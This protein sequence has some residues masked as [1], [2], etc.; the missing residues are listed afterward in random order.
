MN[1]LR[2][3]IPVARIIDLRKRKDWLNGKE[4][5]G[6]SAIIILLSLIFSIIVSGYNLFSIP[7]YRLGD[8]ARADIVVPEDVLIIDKETTRLRKEEARDRVWPVYRVDRAIAGEKISSLTGAF[9]RSRRLLGWDAAE[10][11]PAQRLIRKRSFQTLTKTEQDNLRA[12]WQVFDIPAPMD[13]LL[14]FLMIEKFNTKLEEQMVAFL[15]NGSTP[16]I[17]SDEDNIAREK[18]SITIFNSVTGKEEV[19][20]L[21]RVLTLAQARNL[22]NKKLNLDSTVPSSW[23]TMIR[24]VVDALLAPN[25]LFDLKMTHSKQAMAYEKADPVLRQ[26]KKGKVILRQGDEV[27]NDHL[28]QIEAFRKFSMSSASLEQV[29]GTAIIIAVLLV[30]YAYFLRLLNIG[31]WTYFKILLFSCLVL[32]FNF[33]LLKI[34]WFICDSISRTFL[35]TPFSDKVY[36][37]YALPYACGAMNIALL[38]GEQCAY[39]YLLFYF[40]LAGQIVGSDFYGLLYILMLNLVGILAVRKVTQ[41]IGVISSGFK[42]GLAAAGLFIAL[43]IAKQ[44]PLDVLN[45]GLGVALSFLSGLINAGI[46]TFL[47][48]LS[49]RLFKVTTEIRLSELGN[50]NNPLIRDLILKAPGTYNHSIAVGT[51]AEAAAKAVGISPLYL[52]VASLYHDIGKVLQPEYFVENQ[53]KINP[54]DYIGTGESVNILRRH[55]EEG[56]KLARKANLPPSI[57][58]MIPQHHGTRPMHFFLEK[59]RKNAIDVAEIKD[60]DFRYLGPKPETKAAAI[61]MLAD[62]IEA[63]TR[64]LSDH[65]QDKLLAL[66][67]KIIASAAQDGQFSQCD[68]SLADID[69]ITF[70]FLETLQSFYHSRIKYPGFNFNEN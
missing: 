50:L 25:L 44:A 3:L 5:Y 18:S 15:R 33:L 69:R 51:L 17:I 23:K 61:L 66:I 2:R 24:I 32:I 55:V 42:L 4:I 14:K 53:Q 57:V 31:Q 54:H 67:Q 35:I 30:I 40:L 45:I 56:I 64:T 70:S 8:I 39:L 59:E 1:I 68:I 43:Q 37:F 34:T 41:R 28:A 63:A 46:L 19:A 62:S 29:A 38:A 13:D 6:V 11:K 27:S 47:L 58:D 48:P 9:S 26:L 10:N 49:E 65:S 36:F 20:P 21:N 16:L 12:I 7:E 52:R 22:V 60:E